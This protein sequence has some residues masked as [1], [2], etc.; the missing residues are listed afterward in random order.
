MKSSDLPKRVALVYDW[1]NT[2]FGGAERVLLALHKIFPDAPL[3]TSIYDRSVAKWAKVFDVRTSYLQEIP[4]AKQ[5][6]R[7]L[8]PLMPSAFEHLDLS[9]YDLVISI[10]SAE[11]K[12]VQVSPRALHLCYLL[13]PTRYLWSH[14]F[15][16]QTGIL[17]PIKAFVFSLL[18][19]WDFKVAQK[20]TAFIPIS[21]L[22]QQRCE[23]YYR[24]KTLPVIYP[25]F[26]LNSQLPEKSSQFKGLSDYYIVVSRLVGYKK[27]ELCIKACI[28]LK[29]KLLIIGDGPDDSKVS[30]LIEF[31]DPES[32][33]IFWYERL[34]DAEL[35]QAYASSI[36][37][38]LPAEEDFG[39][40]ALEAQAFG[41]P[42]LVFRHSGAAEVVKE[43]KSGI[44]FSHQTTN[45]LS[46]AMLELEKKHWDSDVIKSLTSQ[47]NEQAFI[48]QFHE[49]VLTAWNNHQKG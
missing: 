16:Y 36:A 28:S 1:V 8:L 44:H 12:A 19:R 22:V 2:P 9:R 13:T 23:K 40:T 11:A 33:F 42:V 21:R 5:H 18:R 24:R 3:Y 31:L 26:S 45:S 39:I 25:P 20:P 48:E 32:Q 6:H 35:K 27:I 10:T 14:T 41:K 29:R 38:L 49:T 7:E 4:F 15:E 47:Y 34:S 17:K 43:G 30:R 46:T 37:L